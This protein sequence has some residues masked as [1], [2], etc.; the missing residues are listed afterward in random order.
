MRTA[1]NLLAA[2]V[3]LFL[4]AQLASWA[5]WFV[6]A[7]VAVVIALSRELSFRRF[8]PVIGAGLLLSGVWA[9]LILNY[10]Q[11]LPLILQYFLAYPLQPRE[12]VPVAGMFDPGPTDGSDTL[13]YIFL[14]AA[15]GATMLLQSAV[16]E[17]TARISENKDVRVWSL[18]VGLILVVGGGTWVLWQLKTGWHF[19]FGMVG[20][21]FSFGLMAEDPRKLLTEFDA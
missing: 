17:L 6:P 5:A 15:I 14:G 7:V 3:G 10:S 9:T 8:Y 4:L 1:R 20:Y 12:G 21:L 18:R 19:L 2:L 16:F 13:G 11:H